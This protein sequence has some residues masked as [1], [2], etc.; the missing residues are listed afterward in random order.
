M[1]LGYKDPSAEITKHTTLYKANGD[2]N[3][4]QVLHLNQRIP[5]F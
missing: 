5:V 4:P 2:L 1:Q 3:L